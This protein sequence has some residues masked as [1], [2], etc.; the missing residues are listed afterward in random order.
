MNYK[1]KKYRNN[2]L[3]NKNFNKKN[4]VFLLFFFTS[5]LN[6]QNIQ[7]VVYLNKRNSNKGFN[8]FNQFIS[9]FNGSIL[10]TNQIP[11]N[12]TPSVSI[13]SS[14]V[15]NT[16]CS[17]ASVTFTA[18]PTDAVGP[19][20]QWKKNGLDITNET[21]STYTTNTLLN[22]DVI[23]VVMTI[24]GSPTTSN[25]ITTTVNALPVLVGGYVSTNGLVFYADAANSNSYSGSGTAWNDIS[26]NS[27]NSTLNSTTYNNAN[28]GSLQFNGSS[29]SQTNTGITTS[30]QNGYTLIQVLKLNS[31]NGGMF[32][33]NGGG[34]KY[35]NFYMGGSDKMRWETYAGNSIN[36]TT[37]VPT[38]NWVI[39]TGTFSG[40][41][42]D[43]NTGTAKIYINGVLDG[44]GTLASQASVTN[45]SI[46]I[47]EYAGNMDG[48]IGATLFYNRELSLTEVQD[49]YNTFST[50]YGL[51]PINNGSFANI[52]TCSNSNFFYHPTSDLPGTVFSWSRAAVAGISNSVATGNDD[53]NEV[54]LNTTSNPLIVTYIYTL[55][56]N[57][58]LS[59]KNIAVAVN[60]TNATTLTS[61]T[62]T[63]AQTICFNNAIANITYTTTSASGISNSGI[64]G[65]NGLP[66][67]VTAT[68]VSNTLTISGI[69]TATGTFNY[70]I[71]LTGCCGSTSATGTIIVKSL[72]TLTNFNNISKYY[73]DAS[74]IINSPTSNSAGAFTFTSDNYAIATISGSTATITG[75]GN[76]N[77]TALQTA[78]GNYC[79]GSLIVSLTISNI[80]VVTINGQITSSNNNYVNKNGELNS[81]TGI[82]NNGQTKA[83]ISP[84]NIGDSYAGGKIAYIFQNN[85]S[86]YVA[87]E[88]HGL[89]AASSDVLR[90]NWCG[91][92]T[93]STTSISTGTAIRTGLANTLAIIARVGNTTTS[94]AKSCRDYRGGNFSDWYLPSKDELNK[95]FINKTAIGNFVNNYYWSSSQYNS[96]SAY[97]QLFS[98][99]SST[100][101]T[102]TGS[103]YVRPV[104]TF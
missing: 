3:M 53:I 86:G 67:G 97:I 74:F 96:S 1:G 102:K 84:L 73:Y 75:V 37:T 14:A 6:A 81:K 68:F 4:I 29:Y 92:S 95:L 19:I 61:T 12:F 59:T 41:N 76:C 62:G 80:N 47:G 20:Y 54:L 82:N 49:N 91:A 48:L 101:I 83:T 15:N 24:S 63:D 79:S 45:T 66:A 104:R 70:N 30:L 98:S 31:Y 58:C 21:N 51:A 13:S 69:P 23:S 77:I 56:S 60:P 17:G 5:L 44:T 36:S 32:S 78:N 71:P 18:T 57:G 52:T 55:T 50:R 28:G 85:E 87:G 33:Y 26:G 39:V 34:S 100:W 10:E 89:I 8:D 16:I 99:G 40:V 22:N 2:Q 103:F 25:L 42:A 72:P 27:N 7:D 65:A 93:F 43:G 9:N 35:L 90:S 38:N 94:A 64:A 88:T 46:R 11:N